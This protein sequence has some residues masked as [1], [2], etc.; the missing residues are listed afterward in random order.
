M[1]NIVHTWK[2]FHLKLQV[3]EFPG[4]PAVGTP[5][6]HC[7]KG[8]GSIPGLGTK[9]LHAPWQGPKNK[10]KKENVCVSWLWWWRESPLPCPPHLGEKGMVPQGSQV[11]EKWMFTLKKMFIRAVNFYRNTSTK[12]GLLRGKK[13]LSSTTPYSHEP[14][15]GG[16]C[17]FSFLI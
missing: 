14:F 2:S 5:H 9:I 16:F 6:F 4:S 7:W 1:Y 12:Q 13:G 17:T 10:K 11:N 3:R 8:A 15:P